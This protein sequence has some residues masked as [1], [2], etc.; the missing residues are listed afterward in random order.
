M[1]ANPGERLR[2]PLPI[3][4]IST[5]IIVV[6]PL[7]AQ[8]VF[9]S[10]WDRS[11]SACEPTNGVVGEGCERGYVSYDGGDSWQTQQLPVRGV[12]DTGGP[13]VAQDGRLYA[14]NVCNDDSCVHLLTSFDGGVTWHALDEQITASKQHVCDL[15]ATATGQT[16]YAVAS[17]YACTQFPAADAL[18]Q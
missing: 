11:S 17:Q 6:S 5:I 13:I 10:I 12:L 2:L 9:M 1:A 4:D 3:A 15:A 8:T 18:A 14:T 16:V 7:R